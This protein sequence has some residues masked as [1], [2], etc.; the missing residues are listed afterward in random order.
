MKKL[1]EKY[2]NQIIKSIIYLGI[3]ADK[4]WIKAL[5]D[6]VG[7]RF[8]EK[9]SLAACNSWHFHMHHCETL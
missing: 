6:L 4:N 1:C 3:D 5:S 7:K 8:Y 9:L 2:M